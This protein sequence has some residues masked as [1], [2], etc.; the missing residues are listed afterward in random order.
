[1]RVAVEAQGT[2][3]IRDINSIRIFDRVVRRASKSFG[4][5]KAET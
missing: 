2:T 3:L 4:S 5:H 1:M